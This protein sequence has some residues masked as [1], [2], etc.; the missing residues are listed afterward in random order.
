MTRI[1]IVAALV[2]TSLAACG[3]PP[4]QSP[5]PS[6]QGPAV[7]NTEILARGQV[8]RGAI[9]DRARS[10]GAMIA[11]NTPRGVVL[12]RVLPETSPVLQQSCGPHIP[13]RKVRIILSTDEQAGRTIVAEQRYIVDGP[14]LC[15]IQLNAADVS[16]ANRSLDELK[17]QVEGTQRAAR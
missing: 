8:V 6:V 17:Q 3:T 15:A 11:S 4:R 16:E 1:A 12:E 10:R 9:V 13:G 14:N 7:P 2:A 5:P